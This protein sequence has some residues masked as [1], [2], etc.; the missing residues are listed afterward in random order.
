MKAFLDGSPIG[1][2]RAFLGWPANVKM[3]PVALAPG[4]HRLLVKLTR[5]HA[6]PSLAV[7]LAREDGA[8]CDATWTPATGGGG[9]VVAGFPPPALLQARALVEALEPEAGP[10]L[11]RLVAAGDRM[12]SDRQTSVAL[13]EEAAAMLPGA[14]PILAARG[15]ALSGD[16]S[17]ADRTARTRAEAD[18]QEAL[19]LDPGDAATRVSLAELALA[20]D[21]LDD[22][23]ALLRGLNDD[24]ARS[25]RA[26]LARARLLSARSFPEAAEVLALEAWQGAGSCAGAETALEMA[27]RRE[28]L[29]EE[30]ELAKALFL[31]PGGR[32]R[33]AEQRRIRG[34]AS[35][36]ARAWTAVSRAAPARVDARFAL[37]RALVAQGN[38]A[39]AA[40]ELEDLSRFWP[41]DPRLARR[42]G[43]VLE[44]T[45]E[46]SRARSARERALALDG[47]DLALRRALALQD[48][49][50]VLASLAEDGRKAMQEYEA[51]AMHPPTSAALVLDAAA[52]ESYPDGSY[53]ERIHQVTQVLDTKG[54]ERWGEV[55]VPAGAAL[56]QLKTW[57]RDGRVLEAEDPGGD[58]RTLSAA[59]LEPGDY[60]EVEWMRGRP[61]RGPS[62]PGWS[63]DPFYLRGED[64][65]FFHSTYV[66]AAPAGALEVDARNLAAP[67]IVREGTRD[68][69]RAEAWR[70]PGLVPEPDS[71]A[72][73]E[74]FPMVQVGTGAGLEATALSVAD[75][76]SDRI[77]T[78]REIE[79]LAASVRRPP[80]SAAPLTGEP[81]VR[82][83]YEKVMESVEGSGSLGDQACQVL[84]RGRGSRTLVLV[85][86][87]DALGFEARLALVRPFSAD[88]AHFRFP[89]IDLYSQAM[90]RVRLGDRTLWL[91]PSV[92][93]APFGAIPSGS[94]D[95]DALVLPRPGESLQAVRTP[96]DAGEDR[97]EVELKIAVSPN[98]DAVLEGS[99]RFT[100]FD[101]AGAKT[102]LEQV[103]ARGR[104]QVVEHG[105]GRSFRGLSLERVEVEGERRTGEPLVI[106]YRARVPGLARPTGGRLVIDAVP[107]PARLSVRFA[108]LGARE[109]PLLLGSAERAS[110]RIV[111]LPP[112]GATPVPSPTRDVTGAH[113]RYRREE[114]LQNGALVRKDQIELGRSRLPPAEYSTF[115]RF[116]AEVDEAQ[117]VPMDLGTPPQ[118]P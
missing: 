49:S 89:R 27:S 43:E 10:A 42:L 31:C 68:V 63:A 77:K 107:F 47:S 99:E 76:F 39:A 40:A 11:A 96:A 23:E 90:V 92:R 86:L 19:R 24:A 61:A 102:A 75:T 53:T 45:G 58:K 20:S 78:S 41:R 112:P 56:L 35:S 26:L 65:P 3:V 59:G 104:R 74:F 33:L 8:P 116:A 115:V 29:A 88:P 114:A 64:L 22:A 50:D 70:V 73:S 51:A 1:E 30:D 36:A 46:P 111:V 4:A 16:A 72:A 5:G 108:Q 110:V 97:Y 117:A 106:R 38:A 15:E 113:G 55:E 60:L 81:L 18:W 83:A 32:E 69:V 94:R 52:V 6:R 57:K 48:G 14:P 9:K 17:L 13:L 62:V 80:G 98:G 95:A 79:S 105:L 7:A 109:T 66:V 28:A 34:D 100:G 82:A 91:D 118:V 37:A 85:A 21:R 25:P 44:L 93:W 101:A 87:L 84:S 103:D 2:R 71:P 12:D 67:A 54:V